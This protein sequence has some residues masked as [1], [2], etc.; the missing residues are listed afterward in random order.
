MLIPKGRRQGNGG[1][2]GAMRRLGWTVFLLSSSNLSSL[3][4]IV[5]AGF[6]HSGRIRLTRSFASQARGPGRMGEGTGRQENMPLLWNRE[7]GLRV[8][9][10]GPRSW[11]HGLAGL[12]ILL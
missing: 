2:S 3:D 9:G 1:G 6:I 5:L 4:E 7:L 10:L 8:G 11:E 12:D